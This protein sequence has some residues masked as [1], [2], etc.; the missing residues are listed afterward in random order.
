MFCL[1]P[2]DNIKESIFILS[3]LEHTKILMAEKI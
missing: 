3:L 1:A 2:I